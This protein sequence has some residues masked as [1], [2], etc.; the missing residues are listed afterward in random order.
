MPESFEAK[1][2]PSS[3][4]GQ[5]FRYRFET[6][7]VIFLPA[8]SRQLCSNC[9]S[10]GSQ[11]R[12]PPSQRTDAMQSSSGDSSGK[13]SRSLFPWYDGAGFYEETISFQIFYLP[14]RAST[15]RSL[16]VSFSRSKLN[17]KLSSLFEKGGKGSGE[18]RE[19]RFLLTTTKE[20][21]TGQD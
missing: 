15:R 3:S 14:A 8:A 13:I 10:V 4:C 7:D 19:G 21:Q 20:L 16:R 18:G 11:K 2:P 6:K 17:T 9:C 5:S 1:R 12:H